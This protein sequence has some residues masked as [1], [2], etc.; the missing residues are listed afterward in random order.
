MLGPP[1]CVP[2]GTMAKL[3][4]L[5]EA[6]KRRSENKRLRR[7]MRRRQRKQVVVRKS[8]GMK[9]KQPKQKN[10]KKNDWR[11]RELYRRENGD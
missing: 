3:G 7:Y 9:E 8:K 6:M 2:D 4:K 10:K 5:Y 11:P 1:H